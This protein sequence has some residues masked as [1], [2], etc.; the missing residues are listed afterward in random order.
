[1]RL[2]LLAALG[3]VAFA[4][5]GGW[6]ERLI[7]YPFDPRQVAPVDAGLTGVNEQIVQVNDE[8]LV[9]WTTPAKSGKPTVLYFHG[10]AGNLASRAGR[11]RRFMDRG[12]GIVA[13][14][15]RGSSGS[16]GS[17]DEE[18]LILDARR[19]Y[20]TLRAGD[21][22]V[23]LSGALVAYG[24]SL[25]T[26]VTIALADDPD[27]SLDGVILEAPFASLQALAEHHYP[28]VAT[29]VDTFESQWPSETRAATALDMPLLVMHGT[30]DELIP[31]AQGRAVYDAAPS[32]TKTML[33]VKDAGHTDLWRS[34][35]LPKLWR[36]IDQH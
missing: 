13:P 33:S 29:L 12:Y 17:P 32:T 5:F 2:F 25:G 27:T 20:Q 4:A 3:F 23:P 11:F 34:D 36:F 9:V 1:M 24:E 7:L 30:A 10:N 22:D 26:A 6:A 31:H 35:T 21:L 16:S 15:Y 14:A 19:I 8:A 28:S 18:A